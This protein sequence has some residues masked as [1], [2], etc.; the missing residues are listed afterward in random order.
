MT[1]TV[2]G[3]SDGSSL[4]VG[5]CVASWNQSITDRLLEGALGRLDALG[6]TDV[7]VLRVPG[8]LELPVGARALA[9]QGHDAIVAIGAV[10]KGDTDHY[11]IVVRESSSGIAAVA[12][13]YGIPVANG[14]L[15][16]HRAQDA[17]DRAGPDDANK[18]AEAAE[19]AVMTATA[20]EALPD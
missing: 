13:T 20:L 1:R 6:V 10:I 11:N 8:A 15:A 5:I 14:V 7:T 3:K 9:E 12:L 4:R 19:A 18:G 2:V 17:L 16:V